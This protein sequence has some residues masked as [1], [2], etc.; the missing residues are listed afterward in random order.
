MANKEK[1]VK[2]Q[3]WV[4]E[5]F[6]EEMNNFAHG[7]NLATADLYK[8]GIILIKNLISKP[9]EVVLNLFTRSFKDLENSRIKKKILKEYSGSR[10]VY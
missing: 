6:R 5:N 1:L 4:G 8:A 2:V 7:L 3:F 9:G 10:S